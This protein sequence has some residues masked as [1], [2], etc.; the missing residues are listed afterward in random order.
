MVYSHRVDYNVIKDNLAD[1]GATLD[2]IARDIKDKGLD[3]YVILLGDSVAYSGP[4][5]PLQAVSRYMDDIAREEDL[6]PV[7][8]L[9]IPAAQ[10]GDFYTI[11]LMLDERGISTGHV[12]LNLIYGG[13]VLRDPDPPIVYW[14]E[15]DLE[16]LDPAA[17]AE[18][19]DELLRSRENKDR[20]DPIDLFI[21]YRVYSKA[22]V[23]KYRDFIRKAVEYR[24]GTASLALG[25]ARPWYEKEGLAEILKDPMYQRFYDPTP[26]I[27]DESNLNVLFLDKIAL[28]QAGK[29]LTV[30][31]SPLNK[32]LMTEE[33]SDPGYVA[34]A[35]ELRRFLETM[36][37]TLGF[38]YTDLTYSIPPNLFSDHVH[39]TWEGYMKL[40]DLLWRQTGLAERM[41]FR[42]RQATGADALA[43]RI[44]ALNNLG[45]GF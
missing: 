19:S 34:N 17:F 39:L 2:L 11:L 22:P 16:R 12:I 27:L 15:H 8:N 9:A 41:R 4:G 1:F 32:D 13:F 30:F 38:T 45:G 44:T 5:G 43:G 26:L 10:M 14:L 21:E 40:A 36:A 6:P 33:A 7:Y 28:H 20:P 23:L 35:A 24:L 37:E 25:D 42:D 31:M 18:I 29:D 3:D